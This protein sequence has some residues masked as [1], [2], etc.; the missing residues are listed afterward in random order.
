MSNAKR[1]DLPSD[2]AE[3]MLARAALRFEMDPAAFIV[4]MFPW[5]QKGSPLEH[6]KPRAWLMKL[7]QRIKVKLHENIDKPGE[8]W[9]AVQEAIASGNGIGK[10]AGACQLM[11]WA[12]ATFP[13]TRGVVTA[14]TDAQLRTKTWPELVKWHG[15]M[16][17]RH[18]FEVTATAIF[19]KGD[20]LPSQEKFALQRNWRIDAVPWSI[21]NLEA[22]T[23]LHNEG[24][25]LFLLMDE[26]SG[27][28]DPVWEKFDTFLTDAA[29]QIIWLVLGNP[30]RARG[31][32]R[33]CFTKLREFW[34]CVNVDARTVEGTNKLQ[35]EK[36]KRSYGEN[37]Q[38]FQVAVAG[39]F[40]DADANQLI[41][42]QWIAEA[43][44]RGY[45]AAADGS[46]GKL[47]VSVDVSDGGAD[48]T[49]YTAM[50]HYDSVR[51]G[52]RQ[53]SASY[54]HSVAVIEAAKAAKNIF[55]AWG[56]KPGQD[57]IVVDRM[58]V[59]AGTAGT[60]MNDP[61]RLTIIGYAGG[62]SS[63]NP[64]KF[65]N[66]RVQSYLALRNDLRDGGLALLP[67]FVETKEEWDELEAQL[68]SIKSKI[69]SDKLEDLFTREEMKRDGIDSP[70]RAD[71]MAMQYAT[72]MPTLVGAQDSGPM[73]IH[74]EPSS[75]LAG[76]DA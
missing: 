67:E 6:K 11:L 15:L 3:E 13:E 23:G 35:H 62:E 61:A 9:A 72:H 58:G 20:G 31:R 33:D 73:H 4:Y 24:K 39:Q 37:S 49:V 74:I 40:V 42:L 2:E 55:E 30:T 43:R 19:A 32:F 14:N 63:S 54:A 22:F 21:S 50:R 64:K 68:C 66:R 27:I 65:R 53:V 44:M 47:R 45:S 16:L 51:I 75:F 17:C 28:D 12:M 71:S 36:W 25:R 60:L 41:S 69:N 5:G 52:L 18:W 76:Y 59:G 34:G 1:E 48:D 56:G 38:F 8:Q 70:D 10:S 7:C 46:A 26:A 29:T 57:D